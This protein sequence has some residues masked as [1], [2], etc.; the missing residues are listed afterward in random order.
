MFSHASKT[1]Y[2]SAVFDPCGLCCGNGFKT[3]TN[4]A[5]SVRTKTL[6]MRRR[7]PKKVKF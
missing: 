5:H 3:K 1:I 4:F 2:V 6:E 7:S